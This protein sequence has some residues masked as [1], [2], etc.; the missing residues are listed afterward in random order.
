MEELYWVG[1]KESEIRSCINIF[2]GS[3]TYT[4]SGENGNI[5][6]SSYS[7]EILNYNAD[8]D[9]LDAF[10][11]KTLLQLIS[12]NHNIKF[13]FYNPYYA[14]FL[15]GEILKHTISNNQ[16]YSYNFLRDKMKTRL[17]LSNTIPVLE[18]TALS[19]SQC[20]IEFFKKFF[21]RCDLFVLQGCTGAGGNDT[22]IINDES[23]GRIKECLN[24]NEIFLLSPYITPSFSVN[25]HI[26]IGNNIRIAPA[27]IQIVEKEKDRLIFHG[28]D[29]V[30]YHN[31]SKKIRVK[32]ELYSNQIAELIKNMGYKGILGIDFLV[33]KKEVYFLEINPRFQSSTPLLNEAM[34]IKNGTTLQEICLNIYTDSEYIIPQFPND[35][36]FSS[37]IVDAYPCYG[38]YNEYIKN[39]VES[40]EVATLLKDGFEKGTAYEECAS[41]YSVMLKTNITTVNPNGSLNIHDNIKA[42]QNKPPRVNTFYDCLD[43]KTKLLSQG[44]RISKEAEEEMQKEVIRKGTYSSI[45]I[46]ILSDL[47]INAPVSLKLCS[48]SPFEIHFEKDGFLLLYAGVEICPIHLDKKESFDNLKTKTGINYEDLSFLATDRLRL[49]HSFGCFFKRNKC[50]CKFCDVPAGISDFNNKDLTEIIDWH[51]ANSK[52]RHVLIGGGSEQRSIEYIR[53]LETVHYLRSKTEKPIY[54]MAL[55]PENT[56]VLSEYYHAGINEIAFNIEIFDNNLRKKYISGKGSIPLEIYKETLLKAVELWGNTGNVKSS[57][58]YGLESDTSFLSGIEWLASHGIQP[59]ISA[60]RPLMNTELKNMIVPGSLALQEVFYKVLNLCQPYHLNPG[61]DCIYCQNNTL[62]L[63]NDIFSGIH[64]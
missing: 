16:I 9:K 27:S 23:W 11:K 15:G 36:P 33:F 20:S 41:I 58:L 34:F 50:G 1:L 39:A 59:V 22:Y 13:M 45:D 18:S 38:Y 53:I 14:S 4:G 31:I 57:I 40:K 12:E 54:L 3:V 46:Y 60:F 64:N 24:P 21:P 25:V 17:W 32:I 56:E 28:S 43:L 61:P 8:S 62:S 52:F 63:S 47:I 7:G 19:V 48:M 10:I 44:I 30:E 37:Y 51:I 35:V 55:P 6:Y 26:T 2:T 42:Y 5:S 49:H 29:F